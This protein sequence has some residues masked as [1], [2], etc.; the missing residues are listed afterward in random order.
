M[1]AIMMAR[2]IEREREREKKM[3]GKSRTIAAYFILGCVASF[4][5]VFCIQSKT[6]KKKK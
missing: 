1:N 3:K 2:K 4:L 6:R 5:L